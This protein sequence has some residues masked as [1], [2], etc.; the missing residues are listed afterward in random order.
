MDHKPK[1]KIIKLL[2][3]TITENLNELGYGG[4]GL[5]TAIKTKLILEIIE[6]H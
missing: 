4:D 6:L 3:E 2:E 5:D 1:C